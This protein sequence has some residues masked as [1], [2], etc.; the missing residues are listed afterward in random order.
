MLG[1]DIEGKRILDLYAG[2]GSLGIEALSR[3]ATQ[4][5]F[6]E[7][8]RFAVID[9][10]N[11]VQRAKLSEKSM[12]TKQKAIPFLSN[13]DENSYDIVFADPPY[14]FYKETQRRAELLISLIEPLIPDG[15]AIILK[16]P[17]RIALPEHPSL[18]HADSRAFADSMVTIWV[19]K[20]ITAESKSTK[21]S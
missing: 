16:H 19:K 14:E 1:S 5:T 6:V 17:P 11:N 18:I 13:Q 7:A 4:C 20:V 9:I 2:S 8:D 15:G 12:I 10:K 3:G 21:T